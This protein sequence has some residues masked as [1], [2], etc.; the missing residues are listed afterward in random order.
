[1]ALVPDFLAR[2]K[3]VREGEYLNDK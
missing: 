1:S 2:V 3:Q